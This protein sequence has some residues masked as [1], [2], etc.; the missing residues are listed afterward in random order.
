MIKNLKRLSG[1]REC[2]QELRLLVSAVCLVWF[3]LISREIT[4]RRPDDFNSPAKIDELIGSKIIFSKKLISI[5]PKGQLI[6]ECLFD[7]L[8]FPNTQRKI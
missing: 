5:H 6:L 8:N 3:D 7:V 1:L 2:D 4:Q